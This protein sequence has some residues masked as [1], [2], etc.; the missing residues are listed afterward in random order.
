MKTIVLIKQVPVVSAMK[1]DPET[2][3]LKR[4]GVPSEV[5]SFDIRALLKAIELRNNLGGE[6]VALTMGPPQAKAALEHCLALGADRAL[7]L[8][9]RAFA[10]SDTLATARA[11]ALALKRE[12]YDLILCGRHSTDAET[13]QV[14]PEVAEFLGIP[15]VTAARSLTVTG[16]TLTVERETDSGFETVECPLPALLSA[17]EDLAPERFPNKADREKAKE[18]PIQTVTASDL[19]A[20][21][22]QFGVTG[23]PTWVESVQTVEVAR[24]KKMLEGD[25]STQVNTLVQM[26][27]ERGLFGKWDEEDKGSEERPSARNSSGG[28]AVW[29]VAENLGDA[30][31]P[32]TLELLGKAIELSAKYGGEVGALLMG[33]G[34][35]QHVA[36]LAIHGADVV[37]LAED[38]RLTP[39]STD[40]YTALLTRV[41]QEHKPGAVLLGS[42]AIGRDLAPRVAAR[43][44]LGLT[45]DCVDLDVNAQGQLLQYK[46]AFGGN[47]VAP[48]LSRTTTE[49]ATVR[50]GMLKK[51]SPNPARQARIEMLQLDDSVINRVKVLS[52]TGADA[53][54]AAALDSAEIAIGVGKGIGGPANLAVIEQLATI[55]GGAPLAAT[56]DIADLGWLPRQHQVGLTGRAIAPKLYFAIG[57]RGA[58]EHTVGVRRANIIVALNKNPKAPIFQNADVGIVGDYAEI[59]PLLTK[60]LETAK[61][62]R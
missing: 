25:L 56:R 9:D 22:S 39:Y 40:I 11:L 43:L 8:V 15:Q 51:A 31:R 26:L 35:D 45:G 23:S 18:K 7:H 34:V 48:I 33:S 20:D 28:K 59:V 54:K 4:E 32:V 37:Y 62:G 17:T 61:A 12:G 21:L 47:I 53:G 44:S 46:P 3:T 13:G 55:L 42:T 10:G 52:Q 58:F 16:Q 29:V 5:S 57:I 19:S 41:I 50:P 60:A 38:R 27:L 30:L 24:E 49:M 36:T 6:V 2:K 14:G 1:L